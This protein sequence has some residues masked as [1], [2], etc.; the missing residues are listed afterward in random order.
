MHRRR[1]AWFVPF[2]TVACTVSA[3]AGE[4]D[5]GGEGY[6]FTLRDT[7]SSALADF[8]LGDD[9]PTFHVPAPLDLHGLGWRARAALTFRGGA[10][11][12]SAV[13]QHTRDGARTTR[14]TSFVGFDLT[15][16]EDAEATLDAFDARYEHRVAATERFELRLQGGYRFARVSETSAL[17]GTCPV[18][19]ALLDARVARLTYASGLTAH[20]LRVGL[21]S[22][23]RLAGP[24]HL[25]S[26]GGLALLAATQEYTGESFYSGLELSS[27]VFEAASRGRVRVGPIVDARSRSSLATWDLSVRLRVEWK[28]VSAGVG[29]RFERWS[30]VPGP[31]LASELGFDGL[32]FGLGWRFGL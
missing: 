26:E 24:L 25:E 14:V 3:V 28:G 10:E 15:Q 9:G 31:L 23:V 13:C 16:D 7:S 6:A 2:L 11:R 21:A 18:C 32:T 1:L 27:R 22:D 17:T 29:Y 5:V 12:V 4:F 30:E 20:G 8:G 19:R